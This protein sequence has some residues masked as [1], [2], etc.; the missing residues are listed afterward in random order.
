MIL[1]RPTISGLAVAA[2]L[3]LIPAT[4]QTQAGSKAA[5]PKPAPAAGAQAPAQPAA[6]PIVRKAVT[7]DF[8]VMAKRRIIRVLVPHSKTTYFVERGQP[9]GIAYE[10][11]QAFGEQINKKRGLE[12]VHIV[13]FPTTRDK[14]LSDLV[15]GLGDIVI[16]GFTI[17]PERDKLVD[18]TIP[19]DY[20]AGQRNCRHRTAVAA[21]RLA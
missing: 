14:L 21:A 11:M 9:R 15:A 2:A 19:V 1:I 13:F 18:F 12:K 7:G 8:D 3:V 6:L 5:P 17:T 10:A 16:A 4:P 20:Q